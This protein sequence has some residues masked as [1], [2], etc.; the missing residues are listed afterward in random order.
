MATK[1]TKATTSTTATD[2]GFVQADAGRSIASDALGLAGFILFVAVLAWAPFPLGSNRPWSWSLLCLLIACCW[3]L[4]AVS[5]WR[6]PDKAT[7]RIR[8]VIGPLVLGAVALLWAVV[9]ILPVVP[10]SWGH[11]VWQLAAQAMGK[12]L[13]SSISLNP[14]RTETEFMKLFC[15]GLTALLAYV[16]AGRPERARALLLSLICIGAF[17]AAYAFVM[18]SLGE[19]QLAIFYEGGSRTRDVAG[20]FVNHNSYATYAGLMVLCAGARLIEQ[21]WA[22]VHVRQGIRRAALLVMQYLSGSGI[23][24]LLATVLIASTLIA[25]GSRGGNF[26]TVAAAIVLLAFAIRTASRHSAV[27]W[28]SSIG[29]VAFA[30]LIV[31]FAINGDTLAG[32]LNDIATTGIHEDTRLMLWNAASR[33]IQDAPFLGLGLG[34]FENAYPMYADSMMP[35]IMDRA[36]NDYLEIAAGWGLPACILWGSAIVWLTSLC[37]RGVFVRLRDRI[38]PM[39]AVAGSVLVGVHSM[40]DFSLQMPAVS[41]TYAC[42]LGLGVAQSFSSRRQRPAG[43]TSPASSG[44]ARF[45]L[46]GLVVIPVLLIT[47]LA[48]PRFLGGLAQDAAVPYTS[49]MIINDPLKKSDYTDAADLLAHTS[50]SDG[51]SRV[52][53]ALAMWHAGSGGASVVPVA[54]DALARSPASARGWILLAEELRGRSPET[55][56]SALSLGIMLA[57]REYYLVAPRIRAGAPLWNGLSPRAQ[58]VLMNDARLVSID[59]NLEPA[60]RDVLRVPG[61]PALISRAFT[62]RPQDLRALNRA[63]A[64]KRLGI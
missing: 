3:L 1:A 21:G 22:R 8:K 44:I 35:L 29:L 32:R 40:F 38:Y 10:A 46:R 4:W 60:L 27:R 48:A 17:Y 12:P 54:E 63:L 52:M 43:Q 25:T 42:V 15:Y 62:G 18:V 45:A 57:P 19:S 5:I 34:T 55:A 13:A 31:L 56:V 16:H 59:P 58:D 30:G 64:R 28:V 23:P 50:P 26:A 11:P 20:P 24:Y 14:W 33:M 53:R 6:A 49:R 37:L 41:M 36:H 61:G 9:Q 51:E 39:L 47:V 2:I 7:A